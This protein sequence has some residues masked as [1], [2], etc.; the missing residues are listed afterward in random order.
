MKIE[1]KYYLR[2][3]WI[4]L[5]TGFLMITSYGFFEVLMDPEVR[6]IIKIGSVMFYVGLLCLFLI[7]LRQ[8]LKERKTDK[9]TDVEI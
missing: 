6:T 5:T 1:R 3:S 9:Y 7:V 2:T 4:I 8:R